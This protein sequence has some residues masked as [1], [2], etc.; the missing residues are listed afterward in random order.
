ML[1]AG[2][3]IGVWATISLRREGIFTPM[4]SGGHPTINS[5]VNPDGEK[6]LYN[7]RQPAGDVAN[8]LQ[9]WSQLLRDKGGYSPDKAMAPWPGTI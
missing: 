8:Y 3:V 9:P 4:D 6:A 1:G 2:P 5:V 7:S